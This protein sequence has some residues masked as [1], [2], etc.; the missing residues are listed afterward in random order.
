LAF[1][2]EIGI[3]P[4]ECAGLM[5][6]SWLSSMTVRLVPDFSPNRTFFVPENPDPMMVTTVPPPADPEEGEIPVSFGTGI[7]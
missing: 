1:V 5:I 3:D 2:I 6:V 7:S 4:G